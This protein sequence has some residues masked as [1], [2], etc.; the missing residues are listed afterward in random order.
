MTEPNEKPDP[1]LTTDQT[2]FT[3][4]EPLFESPPTL[5]EKKDGPP[6]KPWYRKPKIVLVVA[7]LALLAFLIV[8]TM[9]A[10]PADPMLEGTPTPTPSALPREL[11]A[12]EQRIQE[13]MTQLQAADPTKQE[14]P[15]PPVDMELNVS[16]PESP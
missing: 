7:L 6:Q 2:E 15:F 9:V 3:F 8:A 5:S 4:A 16:S 1:P 14:F 11:S 12:L 10:Q 13:A